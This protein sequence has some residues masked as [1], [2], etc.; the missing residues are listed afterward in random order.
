MSIKIRFVTGS[1]IVSGLIRLQ[2]GVATPFTPS[3]V[4][5]VSQDGKSYIGAHP[6][7]GVSARPIGYDAPFKAELIV[8]LPVVA[9][10]VEADFYSF[11]NSKLGTPYDWAAIV[12]FLPGLDLHDRRH[13]ICSAFIA[14][15][16]QH[17]GYFPG[18]LAAPPH[19]IS[20][21]DL[22]LAISSHVKI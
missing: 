7:G 17:C 21:R 16:L 22:L 15:A 11:V 2:A 13:A 3:H 6:Q 8:E 14:A 4:E 18:H 10:A 12:G 20:P 9:P 1:D 5:C 19:H